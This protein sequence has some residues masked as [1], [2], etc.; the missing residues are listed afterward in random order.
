MSARPNAAKGG[1]APLADTPIF[2]SVRHR[3]DQLAETGRITADPLQQIAAEELD[4]LIGELGTKR[5]AAKSSALGW[6]FGKRRGAR[7]PVR[8]LYIHGGVGRGKTMLMD[9]F[10]EL[11]PVRRKRRVHFNDFMADVHDRIQRQRQAL[12]QGETKDKDPLPPVARSLADEA[13][14]LCFDE[15][16]VTDIADAM[17]LSRLFSALFAHGVVVVATSNV[18]PDDLYRDGLNRG[19]FEPFIA[20]LKQHTTVLALNGDT[21]YRQLKLSEIPVYLTPNDDL[22]RKRMDEAWNAAISGHEEK[23]TAVKVKGREIPVPRANGRSARFGFADL[24]SKPLAARDYL[25]IAETFDTI[26]VDDIPVLQPEQRNE[27][28]RLILLVDTLYDKRVRL[29]ASAEA[30]PAGLYPAG[31][32]REMFE[33]ERTASRLIEMQSRDWQA[34]ARPN[35]DAGS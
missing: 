28:K 12:K 8:G 14:V 17:I 23:A 35:T 4:R 25:A 9:M 31:T 18:A 6:L 26:F 2:R 7:E 1:S 22:A 10:F 19:L 21:D 27:A 32:G 5:L 15:F 11:V 33:F 30:A 16:S 20:V 34:L 24:C 29:F 13:W 3:Y